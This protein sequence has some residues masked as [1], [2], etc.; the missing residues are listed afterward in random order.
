MSTA[1][2]FVAPSDTIRGIDA[3]NAGLFAPY[4]LEEGAEGTPTRSVMIGLGQQQGLRVYTF[5]ID[6][7]FDLS[8]RANDRLEVYLVDP[9]NPSQTLLGWWPGWNTGV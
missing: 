5:G 3:L 9:C 2:C 4:R 7:K 6:A 8:G 1:T